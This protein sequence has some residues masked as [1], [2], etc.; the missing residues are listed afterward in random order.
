MQLN[1]AK[2]CVECDEIFEGEACPVCG[3]AV[4]CVWVQTWIPSLSTRR[5]S[6]IGS[7]GHGEG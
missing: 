2:F 4:V 5:D 3:S 7:C 6:I 1:Q